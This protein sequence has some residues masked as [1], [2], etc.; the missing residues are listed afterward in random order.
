MRPAFPFALALALVGCA[1]VTGM[2]GP[3]ETMACDYACLRMGG[4]SGVCREDRCVCTGVDAGPDAEASVPLDGSAID[5]SRPDAC[6]GVV[7][8]R[9]CVDLQSDPENCGACGIRCDSL[10]NIRSGAGHCVEGV[11]QIDDACRVG[12]ANCNS[13]DPGGGLVDGCE[14][15]VNV[16]ARCGDCTTQ[17][18]GEQ[19]CRELPD[20]RPDASTSTR[21]TCS[22]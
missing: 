12:Y 3:C 17:C 22:F 21:F 19:R 4:T 9:A 11:C 10:P 14:A 7:C 1:P 8:R 2:T 6:T 18:R 16:Y 15:E 5:A 13:T 20:D